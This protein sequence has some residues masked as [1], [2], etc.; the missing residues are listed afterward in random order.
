MI[1]DG[2][3]VATLCSVMVRVAQRDVVVVRN[4]VVALLRTPVVAL[5]RTPV[6][7][8]VGVTVRARVVAVAVGVRPEVGVTARRATAVGVMVP[9]AD[10]RACR[11]AP[12]SVS[13]GRSFPAPGIEWRSRHAP[14]RLKR[15]SARCQGDRHRYHPNT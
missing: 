14:A 7:A 3:D 2:G 11:V 5:L 6:V 13:Q 12:A 4:T 15:S 10:G 1:S 9:F 8:T